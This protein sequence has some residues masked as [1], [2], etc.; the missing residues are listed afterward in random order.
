MGNLIF[1]NKRDGRKGF[2]KCICGVE[3]WFD[4]YNVKYGKSK[5]CGCI[6]NTETSEKMKGNDYWKK[7]PRY[8]NYT[9]KKIGVVKVLKRI[10]NIRKWTPTYI[11]ECECGIQFRTEI[12]SLRRS[13][14]KR[15][16]H[17]YP[18]HPVKLT[19]LDMIKRC[20]NSNNK[21]Y[22]YYGGKGIEICKEWRKDPNNFVEWSLSNG[23]KENLTIDRIDSNGDYCPENCQ[24]ISFNEN[25]SKAQK[26]RRANAKST[27]S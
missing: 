8:T 24:W 20:Y 15:C 11:C 1:L 25:R 5:S 9:G 3:K 6:R 2:F 10:D 19:L 14:Y 17:K 21:G 7:N 16:T 26:K 23:W 27:N 13:N 18:N 22:K 12:S 4:Y